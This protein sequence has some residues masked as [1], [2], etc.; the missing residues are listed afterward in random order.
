[1]NRLLQ[2]QA[3]YLLLGAAVLLLAVSYQ[4]AFRHTFA[5]LQLRHK[6]RQE[7]AGAGDLSVQPAYLDRKFKNL[8]ELTARY[9]ADTSVFRAAV[10]NAVTL[11]A[12]EQ[13]A[14]LTEVPGIDTSF[15]RKGLIVQKMSLKGDFFS[16]LKVYDQLNSRANIGLVRSLTIK[17]PPHHDAAE[18]RQLAM[19]IYLC[20]I[21]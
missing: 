4:L 9:R 7:L 5:A 14:R 13:H 17:E 18:D 1:M 6:L 16:L 10:I 11:I 8:D 19:D 20:G 2:Y 12:D 3:R 21:R 15:N